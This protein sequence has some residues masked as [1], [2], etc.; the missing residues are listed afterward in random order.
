MG[1]CHF[2]VV[3]LGIQLWKLRSSLA[4]AGERHVVEPAVIRPD[5]SL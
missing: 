1:E 5:H 2:L 4:T 3:I